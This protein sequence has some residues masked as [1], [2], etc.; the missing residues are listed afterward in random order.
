MAQRPDAGSDDQ[1]DRLQNQSQTQRQ[2]DRVKKDDWHAPRER[3][4]GSRDWRP[5]SDGRYGR[6]IDND[7]SAVD[8]LD[9]KRRRRD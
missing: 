3:S 4:R 8:W 1:W 9:R 5:E 2:V 6:R 7:R